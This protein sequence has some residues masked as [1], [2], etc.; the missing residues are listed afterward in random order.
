MEWKYNN[1]DFNNV[2]YELMIPVSV[3]NN[4]DV[5][6]NENNQHQNTIVIV[7]AFLDIGRS[8]WEYSYS[9][10]TQNYLSSIRN[11]FDIDYD[12]IVYI[13]EQYFDIL[14][15]WKNSC[16]HGY[17]KK[18]IRINRAWLHK[19]CFM[20]RQ[21]EKE[22]EI[23]QSDSYYKLVKDRID[24]G[25]PE[26][27]C[28]EYNLINHCKIDF[29]CHAIESGYL[30]SGFICWSDFG[31]FF[32]I[33]GN[34]SKNFP[35]KSLDINKFNHEK[36]NFCLRHKITTDDQDMIKTLQEAPERFT[37]SFFGGP[38]KLMKKFQ[39]N[40]HSAL[41]ELHTN[42]IGDDDQH[43]YLRAF[44]KEPDMFQLYLD[45]TKWPQA[46][47]FFQKDDE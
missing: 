27:T 31:Y 16:I 37:G 13:D 3:I 39:L 26:N 36:I 41:H 47:V 33:L 44:L 34:D 12:M 30:S 5:I 43:L 25:Y 19:H 40:C 20:W 29:I 1:M 6:V 22:K 15:E 32:S 42:G 9:R 28:T 2:V 10:D 46:L 18:L 23:L 17:N 14:D 7:T 4:Q 35:T 21:L 45:E 38:V 24:F 11:Y 8:D